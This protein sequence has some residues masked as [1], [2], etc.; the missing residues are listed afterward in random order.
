MYSR[1]KKNQYQ[2]LLQ[3]FSPNPGTC[4]PQK[5]QYRPKWGSVSNDQPPNYVTLHID[6]LF[7]L[8]STATHTQVDQDSIHITVENDDDVPM[9][10]IN[11][12]E[13]VSSA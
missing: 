13:S 6:N 11:E 1:A 2:A 4:L 12:Y 10:D 7:S 8:I 3:H 9:D 5:C